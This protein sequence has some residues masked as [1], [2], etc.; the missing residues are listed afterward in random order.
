LY[1]VAACWA[2]W[3]LA[4]PLYKWW[5]FLLLVLLSLAVYGLTSLIFPGTKEMVEEKIDTG[6]EAL[7][8]ILKEQRKTLNA[9][10]ELKAKIPNQAVA[11]QITRMENALTRIGEHITQHP[12]K[13]KNIRKFMNYY[14]PTSEKLLRAYVE[15]SAQGVAGENIE[16]TMKSVEDVL[17][18]VATA[19]EKQLDSL[20]ANEA[21]DISTD[22]V[23]LENM[24]KSEG[25]SDGGN[26]GK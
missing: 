20:F 1:F 8:N 24:L 7:D 13:A 3:A 2:L 11:D 19:F 6:D 10:A 9:Y 22:I 18:T 5:H 4:L 25:L 16:N 23:V 17:P 12:D 21:M 26:G 14:L 15:A